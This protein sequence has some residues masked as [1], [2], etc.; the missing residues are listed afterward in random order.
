VIVLIFQSLEIFKNQINREFY[1]NW[2][3]F[4]MPED[5]YEEEDMEESEDEDDDSDYDDDDE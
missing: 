1:L 2:R 4:I 3:Y 5:E